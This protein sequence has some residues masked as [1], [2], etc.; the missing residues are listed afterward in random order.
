MFLHHPHIVIVDC[1]SPICS[2]GILGNEY[3]ICLRIFL[4]RLHLPLTGLQPHA[5][6]QQDQQEEEGAGEG[7]H[8][9]GG[10]GDGH[11][12]VDHGHNNGDH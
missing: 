12:D 11:H 9:G 1:R 7:V 10:G 8:D 5:H 3:K 2:S 6:Q 4:V